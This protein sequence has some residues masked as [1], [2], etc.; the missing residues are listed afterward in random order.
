[1]MQTILFILFLSITLCGDTILNITL[2]WSVLEQGGSITHL[3]I[4]ITIMS[5]VPILLQKYSFFLKT[6]LKERPLLIFGLARILGIV[7]LLV[8]LIQFS[9]NT[10]VYGLYLIGGIF[11]VIL[12]LSNQSLEIYM[13]QMVL[14]GKI[15]SHKASHDLQTAI[16]IG[17]FGGSAVTGILLSI[18]GLPMISTVL[19]V[20]LAV[21]ML[22]PWL[23]PILSRSGQVEQ[24]VQKATAEAPQ[25]T[26]SDAIRKKVL[27]MTILAVV[28]LTIQLGAINFIVPILF[29]DIY[30]WDS[31]RYG[32][33]GAA[34]GLGAFLA[35]L[36]RKW[37]H[38][39]PMYLFILIGVIDIII[40]TVQVFTV[41]LICGFMLGFVFNR[42]RIM[43]RSVMFDNLRS[44]EETMKWS[45][46]STFATQFTRSVVPL[47]LAL[48]LSL[49]G[50]ENTGVLLGTLGV[51]V[52][53]ILFFAIRLE[54]RL[55]L[56]GTGSIIA[57]DSKPS[58]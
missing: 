19:M 52:T 16:Q 40:G 15:K 53:V 22:A 5:L 51:T 23:I 47:V 30:N 55:P 20:T 29:H 54:N 57:G 6:A 43:Q 17:A 12:F 27:N 8:F 39:I 45:G 28:V 36:I 42:T 33:M 37:E 24:N 25:I 31:S 46:R 49:M 7:F 18:G 58:V 38:R 14:D 3:S 11:S 4:I 1:M 50:Q 2:I 48:P 34:M 21:G 26:Y 10:N 44:R 13:S 56:Q 9:G 32:A 41:S 35:T